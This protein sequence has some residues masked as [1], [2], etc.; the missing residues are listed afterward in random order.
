MRF[1]KILVDLA[2]LYVKTGT[3]SLVNSGMDDQ[4]VFLPKSKTKSH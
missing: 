1:K 2:Y 3:Y 4:K